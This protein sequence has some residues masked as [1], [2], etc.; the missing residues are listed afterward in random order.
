M[1]TSDTVISTGKLTD[2]GP[3]ASA[4]HDAR[5]ALGEGAGFVFR[6]LAGCVVAIALVWGVVMLFH[7]AAVVGYVLLGVVLLSGSVALFLRNRSLR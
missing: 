4:E 7:H 6:Q 1:S 5:R 2:R 3:A